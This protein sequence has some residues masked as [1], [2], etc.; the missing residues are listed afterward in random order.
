[1]INRMKNFLVV[2]MMLICA[3]ARA[4][5]SG[6]F[7][8]PFSNP[9]GAMKLVIDIKTGSVKVK[10]TARKDVLVKYSSEKD[11][12][13]DDHDRNHNRNNDSKSNRDGLKKIGSG[14]MNLEASEYQ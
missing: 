6:E 5:E 13:D 2:V 10:G 8:V 1:M 3:L 12:E 14:T 4:Q 9:A 11:D 7:T